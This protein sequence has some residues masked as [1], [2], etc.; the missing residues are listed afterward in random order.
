MKACTGQEPYLDDKQSAIKSLAADWWNDLDPEIQ[1]EKVKLDHSTNPLL[2]GTLKALDWVI[3]SIALSGAHYFLIKK[4][5]EE[6]LGHREQWSFYQDLASTHDAGQVFAEP[7]KLNDQAISKTEKKSISGGKVYRCKGPNTF[8]PLNPFF[9]DSYWDYH[10][11]QDFI[12]ELWQHDDNKARPTYICMHGYSADDFTLNHF[13]FSAKK[14]YKDGYNVVFLILPFHHGKLKQSTDMWN[15]FG[16]GPAYTVE[17]FANAVHNCRSLMTY[18]LDSGIASSIHLSGI[19][20]GG[21]VSSLVVSADERVESAALI[22][23]VYNVPESYMEWFPLPGLFNKLLKEENIEF[24]VFRHTYAPCNAL[25]FEPKVDTRKLTIITGLFDQIAL[26]KHVRLLGE[27]WKQCD[28]HWLN[29]GHVGFTKLNPFY[30]ELQKHNEKVKTI[31]AQEPQ[32]RKADNVVELKQ[33]V[34][35]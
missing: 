5:K 1:N 24:P 26:P 33:A 30:K 15:F 16:H 4:N 2:A 3:R 18:L 34:N 19:S 27:H 29:Y 7:T 28:I 8:Q 12:F 21:F 23:P 25:T 32:F 14:L 17:V 35:D 11:H 6:I 9:Q 31:N 13:I 10:K 20:L 22:A